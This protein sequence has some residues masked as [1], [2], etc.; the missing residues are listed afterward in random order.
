MQIRLEFGIGYR[1]RKNESNL[2]LAQRSSSPN[3]DELTA[4]A[5]PDA[6]A[7]ET[8]DPAPE[9]DTKTHGN[10]RRIGR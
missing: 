1:W 7:A 3:G 8:A 4:Q 6:S 2:L 10:R 5:Q 9:K